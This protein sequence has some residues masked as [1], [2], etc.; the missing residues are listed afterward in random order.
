MG[1]QQATEKGTAAVGSLFGSAPEI[2]TKPFAFP[3]GSVDASSKSGAAH[4]LSMATRDD[5]E[6]K[7]KPAEKKKRTNADV[8]LEKRRPKETVKNEAPVPR[9]AAS[10]TT[11]ASPQDKL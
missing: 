9:A 2:G 3:S 8:L 6:C 7:P 1:E 4:Q 11:K 10:A 5:A